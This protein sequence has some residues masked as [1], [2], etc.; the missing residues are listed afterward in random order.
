MCLGPILFLCNKKNQHYHTYT[1]Y[2]SFVNRFRTGLYTVLFITPKG[3]IKNRY[4]RWLVC[5]PGILLNSHFC[6]ESIQEPEPSVILTVSS[7]ISSLKGYIT[8][9]PTLVFKVSIIVYRE[10]CH[11]ISRRRKFEIG[12]T[13]SSWHSCLERIE[14]S[15][16]RC[17]QYILITF[18]RWDAC[19]LEERE[20]RSLRYPI[21]E[22]HHHGWRWHQPR[23]RRTSANSPRRDLLLHRYNMEKLTQCKEA[24]L[25][26]NV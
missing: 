13:K 1:V 16:H 18:A 5:L 24:K 6:G 19:T 12:I 4:L 9:K 7:L 14:I 26:E 11:Q 17:W 22:H 20:F 2:R 3:K 15:W 10:R 21:R 8:G 23:L 25:S